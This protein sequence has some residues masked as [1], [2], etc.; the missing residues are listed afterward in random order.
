MRIEQPADQRN[1]ESASAKKPWKAPVLDS[2]PADRAENKPSSPNAGDG[3]TF[4]GS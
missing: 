1:P 4:C 2:Y 3:I